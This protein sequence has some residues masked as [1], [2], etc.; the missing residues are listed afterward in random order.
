MY[1][2]YARIA[3]LPCRVGA[4]VR[5]LR[6]DGSADVANLYKK[7]GGRVEDGRQAAQRCGLPYGAGGATLRAAKRGNRR[8]V[9]WAL[10][11]KE[12]DCRTSPCTCTLKV[13]ADNIAGDPA[14]AAR[15]LT[16]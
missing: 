14:G 6:A 2:A 16:N 8:T 7:I 3:A 12:R 1:A 4:P 11:R 9:I 5:R 13:L 15:Q 10:L